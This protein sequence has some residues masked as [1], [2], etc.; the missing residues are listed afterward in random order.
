MAITI[1]QD[2]AANV[3]AFAPVILKGTTDRWPFDDEGRRQFNQIISL[4]ENN[5]K[6]SIEIIANG[7]FSDGDTILIS[8]ATGDFEK[9]NGR[10]DVHHLSGATYVVL[11]TG[12]DKGTTGTGGFITRMNDN[13]YIKAVVKNFADTNIVYAT[14]YDLVVDGSFQFDLSKVLQSQLSDIFTLESGEISTTNLSVEVL[15]EFYESYKK[16]NYATVEWKPF[17]SPTATTIAHRT[18]LYTSDYVSGQLMLNDSKM[19]AFNRIVLHFMTDKTSDVRVKITTN[20]NYSTYVPITTFTNGHCAA[21][22]A[23]PVSSDEYMAP[24]K[25]VTLT[26]QHNDEGWTDIKNPIFIS[27]VRNCDTILYYENRL[28]GYGCYKFH[29][30]T[31]EQQSD[32]ID[33]YTSETWKERTLEGHEYSNDA[34]TTVRDIV[35]SANVFDQDGNQVRVLS[36]NMTYRAKQVAPRV[37]IRYDETFI[38]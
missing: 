11:E 20:L 10:H 6:L 7:N 15:V 28:G 25:S 38:S 3:A 24:A 5:G 4:S 34:F 22:I 1:T 9:Y 12:W 36:D 21:A 8:G 19:F 37:K 29:E 31:D 27:R 2:L 30:Y 13:L 16:A 33:K 18:T 14:L 26:V 35:T 23:W 17:G 32:K